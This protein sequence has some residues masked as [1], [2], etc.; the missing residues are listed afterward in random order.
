MT[1]FLHHILRLLS[2]NACFI[3]QGTSVGSY[4]FSKLNLNIFI[5]IIFHLVYANEFDVLASLLYNIDIVHV[6]FTTK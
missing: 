3:L 1:P 2:E 4:H 6:L 5:L